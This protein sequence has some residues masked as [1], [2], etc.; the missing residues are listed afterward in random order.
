MSLEK[1]TF[2]NIIDLR[3]IAPQDS[4]QKFLDF[5]LAVVK[6]YKID[7]PGYLFVSADKK[8]FISS[9]GAGG[10]FGLIITWL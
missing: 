2:G 10:S 7:N 6:E 9:I 3:I 5:K 8:Y 1:P 4:G